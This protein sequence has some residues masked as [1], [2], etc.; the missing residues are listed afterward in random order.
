MWS[1]ATRQD[2]MTRG[3][4]FYAAWNPN[5]NLW[6]TDVSEVLDMIDRDLYAEAEKLEKAGEHIGRVLTLGD[7]SS[8]MW[9][10]FTRYIKS[11]PEWSHQ[12]DRKIMFSNQT[13]EKRDYISRRLGYPLKKGPTPAFDTLFN[14]LYDPENLQKIKWAIGSVLTGDSAEIQKFYALYG[15]P[16][17][18]KSTVL[19]LLAKL[20]DGYHVPVNSADLG[21]S[22]S[23]FAMESLKDNPLVAIDHEGD[24]SRLEVNTL[25]NSIV[26]HDEVTMNVK[27]RSKYRIRLATTIFVATNKPI[28]ITDVKSGLT[29]RLIDIQPTGLQVPPREYD[30]LVG[31]L[32]F[33]LSGIAASCIETYEQLGRRFYDDY[34]AL[35]MLAKTN[36]LF[37]FVQENA[38]IFERQNYVKRSEVWKMYQMYCD[39]SGIQYPYPRYIFKDLFGDYWEE[40]KSTMRID[41]KV[42]REVFYGFKK[43]VFRQVYVESIEQ[44]DHDWLKLGMNTSIF[45]RVFA[46]QPAQLVTSVGG[47]PRKWDN[48]ITTLGDIDT[49]K[50]HMVRPTPNLVM[51]DFDLKDESGNKSLK[52]NLEAAQTWPPTYAET[53]KSGKGLHLYYYY[54][55]DIAQLDRLFGL[56]I[57]IKPPV[58]KFSIRRQLTLCNTQEIATINSGLPLK[59]DK[60]EQMISRKLVASEAAMRTLVLR[61]LT[62]EYHPHTKPSI[63]FIFAILQEGYDQGLEYDLSDLKDAVTEMASKSTNNKDYCLAIVSRM[64]FKSDENQTQYVEEDAPTTDIVF[65]D[66]EVFPNLLIISW[67]LEGDHPIVTWYNPPATR[68]AELLDYKL[69]GFN[70]RMYDNHI[71]YGWILGDSNEDAYLRSKSIVENRSDGYFSKAFGLS[72]TDVHSYSSVKQS[73]KKWEIELGIPYDELDWPWDKPLPEDMWERAGQYC[74]NDVS[75]TEAVHHHRHADFQARKILAALSGLRI[76]D[77]TRAHVQKIIFG[78]D[79]EPQDKFNIPDLSEEFPGYTYDQYAQGNEKSKYRGEFVGEGGYVWAEPGIYENVAY[80]DI[81]SMHPTSLVVLNLFGPYTNNFAQLKDAR[82]AIKEG[83]LDEAAKMFDGKLAPY[84]DNPEEADDLAYALKIA[85]N[86]V[87]G[88]TSTQ[89]YDWAFRDDRNVDNVVAK[90]GAL[91]MVD[92]KNAMLERGIKPV[93][94]K[95]DSVK[96]ANCTDADIQFVKEFG[97]KYGYDFGIEGIFERMVLI[98]DAVLIGKW[99]DSGEWYAVGARFAHPYVYKTLFTREKIEFSDLVET[100]MVSNGATIYLDSPDGRSFIGRVGQFCPVKS[101]GGK[102]LRIKDDKE[103]ALPGTKDYEWLPANVVEG[104]DLEE[105]IDLSYFDALVEDSLAEIAKFGDPETFLEGE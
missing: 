19:N 79:K 104:L 92:L 64:K 62:K 10:E 59:P 8:N 67:K 7:F 60:G 16:G 89:K 14:I 63:D 25:L 105:I 102:L 44:E 31:K 74:A 58:G 5:T 46:Q 53:S 48:N 22:N 70:N 78:D 41:G 20:V 76:N 66:M 81:A 9:L 4:D 26:S 1:V 88:Y 51:I 101:G 43:D 93:H 87:Y 91:F 54:D 77:S 11:L 95:T 23:D 84:L 42:Q 57:E 6:T 17:T 2:L 65:F 33:E 37:D 103:S 68:A 98:N 34:R 27:F 13:P 72:Y 97:A 83:R 29:R 30:R 99:K 86:S 56:D 45:D 18:G 75:A 49:T 39:N 24:L 3:G 12:L 47:L 90:R 73:L 61:N 52:L 28:R 35:E 94:F 32:D 69:I 40:L 21:R 38:F 50:L 71:L 80:L 96:I 82:V 15:K 100:R 36:H 55:G 85:L